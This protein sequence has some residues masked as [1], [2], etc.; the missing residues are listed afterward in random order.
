M[1]SSTSGEPQT[2]AGLRMSLLPVLMMLIA[3]FRWTLR[4][5][6]SAAPYSMLRLK[7]PFSPIGMPKFA[8][9]A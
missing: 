8:A 3:S 7:K 4:L 2:C 6:G 9:T 5:V 1:S